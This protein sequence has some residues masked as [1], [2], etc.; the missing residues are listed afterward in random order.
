M[1]DASLE[2]TVNHERS[3]RLE[4]KRLPRQRRRSACL[5]RVN[6]DACLDENE[7]ESPALPGPPE[8]LIAFRMACANG[9]YKQNWRICRYHGCRRK[10]RCC[11]GPRGTFSR[12]GKPWCA[13]SSYI[14]E[15]PKE[16]GRGR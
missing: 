3:Q 11:G 1:P 14:W 5:D 12:R 6:D 16:T 9:H 2:P 13:G 7:D 4:D 15:E 8:A 10:K